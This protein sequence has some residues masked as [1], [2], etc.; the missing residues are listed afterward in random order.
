MQPVA[1]HGVVGGYKESSPLVFQ[2]TKDWLE[3]L[4]D[5]QLYLDKTSNK[6]KKFVDKKRTHVEY[7]I[8][9]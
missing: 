2:Y 3:R 5:A 1:P 6:M 9:D 7:L 4:V 8:G